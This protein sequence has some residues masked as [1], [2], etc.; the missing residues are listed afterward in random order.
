MDKLLLCNRNTIKQSRYTSPE[1]QAED[2]IRIYEEKNK[3]FVHKIQSNLSIQN[4]SLS[5]RLNIRRKTFCS[6]QNQHSHKGDLQNKLVET[7]EELLKEKKIRVKKVRQKYQSALLD[8][9]YLITIE[10]LNKEVEDVET[11][12]EQKKKEL[13]KK[14]LSS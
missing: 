7:I 8:G 1:A 9:N 13:V 3:S 12:I 11:E 6:G 4:G 2:T 14:L 5:Q 10:Q